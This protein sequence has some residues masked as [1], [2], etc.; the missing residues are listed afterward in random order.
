VIEPRPG[1]AAQE[2][3]RSAVVD[4]QLADR[5]RYLAPLDQLTADVRFGTEHEVHFA[6]GGTDWSSW[7]AAGE[8][9]SIGT[10]STDLVAGAAL[11]LGRSRRRRTA[12]E[13]AGLAVSDLR[14]RARLPR[15]AEGTVG[16]TT[17]GGWRTGRT[18]RPRSGGQRPGGLGPGGAI[19]AWSGPQ[20]S[21]LR[22]TVAA[23]PVTLGSTEPRALAAVRHSGPPGAPGRPGRP[24]PA[25]D[26][27]PG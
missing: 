10:V 24:R 3:I 13:S 17:G 1:R 4:H 2:M 6:G 18:G 5:E 11:L 15:G 14:R 27:E 8:G 7:S 25:S 20:G 9:R 22:H 26:A 16:R 23:P 19:R 12:L 21:P